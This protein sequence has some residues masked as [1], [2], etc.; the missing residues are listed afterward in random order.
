MQGGWRHVSNSTFYDTYYALPE[1]Q[2][3]ARAPQSRGGP[4]GI[5]T[6][7]YSI[8]DLIEVGIDLFALAEQPQLANQPQLTT[9]AYGALLGL[10]FQGWLDIGP[11]G[12]VPFLGILTGPMLATATFKDQPPRE[13]LSQAWGGS[14]G[15]TMHLSPQWGLTVEFR[16]VFARGA[17]GRT[18]QKFGSFNAGG[19]WLTVGVNYAFPPDTGPASRSSF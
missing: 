12:T 11:E 17:V 4:L 3:L 6:F 13:T 18:D 8:T 9:W 19:S 16:Q 7:A 14:A 15:A 2:G 10:R 1:N 5:G